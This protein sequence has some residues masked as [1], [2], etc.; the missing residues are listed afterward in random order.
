MDDESIDLVYLDPPFNS[1]R[2]YNLLFQHQDGTKAAGQ[3]KAF[4]DTWSWSMESARLY[5]EVV[6]GGGDV[7]RVLRAMRSVL[8]PSD[9]LAYLTMMAPRL[10]ELRRVLKD[11]GSLYLHCDPTASHYLKVLLDAVFEATNFR[12]EIVWKRTSA[13]SDA[14][15]GRKGFGSVHD[16]IFFYT[17]SSEFHWEPYFT[18]YDESYL[19][20]EYRHVG[21]DGRPYKEGDLTAAKPGG[22]TE[23]DWHVVRD[24]DGAWEADLA[25]E[26]KQPVAGREYR[27]VKPYTG[28][29]WAYSKDNMRGFA[30]E[31]R[32][33]HRST[34]MPRLKLFADEMPGVGP[35][36]VWTDISPVGAK[37]RER[38][39][40]PTQKPRALLERIIAASCPVDGVVLDP[41]CGCGTAVDAAQKLGRRWI[42]IDITKLAIDV[43]K[44]RFEREFGQIDFVLTGE[45]A[46]IEEAKALAELDKHAFQDWVGRK[47]GAAGTDRKGADRGIDGEWVG[48]YSDGEAWRGILS[49]KGGSIGVAQVRD[50][51]GT[52]EREEADF[53]VYISL[54]KPTAAMKRESADAGFT[55]T[56]VPRL[57][58]LTVGE[59][60]EGGSPDL[61]PVGESGRRSRRLRAV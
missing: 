21:E 11:S 29:Y 24:A 14:K 60:F 58:L 19:S 2:S 43:I 34:G 45:P 47:V 3:I 32:L 42:G 53:G 48:V 23:Y 4:D 17:K 1:N 59:L 51:R 5:D 16:I 22:D 61:P 33:A 54:K 35:Q 36:D 12:A 18:E 49:V 10:V 7:S 28:R 44:E 26:Y 9:M 56:G 52:I 41:F 37:A 6:S 27:A 31:G 46:T 57:Q 8:G 55:E 20:S 50:L 38:V 13:H 25:D 39:G 40:F 15:Q 30:L